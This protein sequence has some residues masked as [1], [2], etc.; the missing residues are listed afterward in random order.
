MVN[1][2]S[3]AGQVKIKAK[4]QAIYDAFD[5]ATEIIDLKD[6]QVLQFTLLE[7]LNQ[8]QNGQGFISAPE[9]HLIIERLA[10]MP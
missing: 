7:V 9:L 10:E 2:V 3:K 5:K 4:A 6:G 1:W 8:C